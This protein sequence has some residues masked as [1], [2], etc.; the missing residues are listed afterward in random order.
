MKKKLFK[1]RGAGPVPPPK[2]SEP[3]SAHVNHL[4]CP[5]PDILAQEAMKEPNR[6]LLQDYRETISIL[7]KDKGFSFREIADWLT[8]NGIAADFNAVYRVY[9]KGMSA[10]E[11]NEVAQAEAERGEG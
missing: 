7:R 5:P 11:E 4:E 8:Q 3:A 10:E 9:T 2:P 1:G 6:K